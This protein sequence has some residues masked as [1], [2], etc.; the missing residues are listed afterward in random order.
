M[1]LLQIMRHL[2]ISGKFISLNFSL[3]IYCPE[4]VLFWNK[5]SWLNGQWTICH[6]D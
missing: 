1:Y 5:F 6:F 2:V 3:K 4:K